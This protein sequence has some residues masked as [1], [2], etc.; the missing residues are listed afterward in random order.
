M[1]AAT[2]RPSAWR[3]PVAR[4]GTL[5]WAATTAVTAAGQRAAARIA[6][7]FR[8][9]A[10]GPAACAAAVRMDAADQPTRCAAAAHG[11][12]A[13]SDFLPAV[14]AFPAH[15]EAASRRAAATLWAALARRCHS[16]RT[17]ST[18]SA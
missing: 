13:V 6:P 18:F 12:E 11:R 7:A 4:A 10:M 14:A 1:V 16:V 3:A 15:R 2:Q 17:W 5:Q 9:V 8:A